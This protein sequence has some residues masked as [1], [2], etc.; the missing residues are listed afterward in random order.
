LVL[1]GDLLLSVHKRLQIEYVGGQET[2]SQIEELGEWIE[3]Q[4]ESFKMEETPWPEYRYRPDV[5]V[6]VGWQ[7]GEILIKFKVR[8][9]SVKAEWVHTN[10]PVFK[11][12]C[13]EFFI[14]AGDG[15]Y[16]NFEFN[17]IGTCLVGYGV[18]RGDR[19]HLSSEIISKIKRV[20]SL[21]RE[22]FSER[23]KETNW[24]LMVVI[25]LEIFRGTSLENPE[26]KIFRANFYK[27]GDELS[28]KHYLVW[29]Y[30][31]TPEPDYHRPEFFGEVFFLPQ[32]TSDVGGDDTLKAK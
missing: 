6:W 14:S 27:C 18:D 1:R 9:Q 31:D 32:R 7:S 2:P 25:P 30:I 23:I 17:P 3:T 8:E 28:E 11:D 21:G 26:G 4:V 20:G 24:E 19:K 10:D 16:F 29:N 22:S 15:K 5:V 13:V 12:S